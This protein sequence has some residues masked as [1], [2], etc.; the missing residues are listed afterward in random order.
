M[1]LINGEYHPKFR[2]GSENIHI[3]NGVGILPNGQLIF[4][5]SKERIN[6]YDFATFFKEKGCENALYLDGFVSRLYLPEKGIEQ[7]DGRFGVI[8]AEIE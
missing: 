6:F 5:I 7:M 3:R 1:V 8:V 2:K 4:A